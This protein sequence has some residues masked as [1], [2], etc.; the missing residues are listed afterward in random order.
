M[1]F[2]SFTRFYVTFIVI[3]TNETL[4]THKL[5]IPVSSIRILF[6]VPLNLYALTEN[7]GE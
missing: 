4:Q 6:F 1:Y 3:A 7:N 5:Q 2:T